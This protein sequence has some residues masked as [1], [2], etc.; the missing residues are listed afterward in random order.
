LGGVRKLCS[1]IVLCNTTK[2]H[3]A[4]FVY[5]FLMF[6]FIYCHKSIGFSSLIIIV[7]SKTIAFIL[8]CYTPQYFS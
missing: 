3:T 5:V 7:R 2:N 4:F 6:N 1:R 8:I